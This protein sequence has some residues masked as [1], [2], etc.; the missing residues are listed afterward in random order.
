[1]SAGGLSYSALVNSGKSTLPSVDGWGT[2]M[3]ILRD[4]PKSITTRKIDKVGSDHDITQQI[5]DSGD[6]ACESIRRF[7]RGVNPSV[8]VSYGNTGSSQSG[9]I[10]SGGQQN[11][12]LPYKIMDG[13][14]F[15][16]PVLRQEQ[17]LPLSR[18]PRATTSAYSQPGRPDYSKKMV[19][20]GKS[21]DMRSV[22]TDTLKTFVRPTK[23]YTI[24]S[25]YSKDKAREPF[26]VKY[27]IQPKL[28]TQAHSGLRTR[29][30]TQQ[31]V[32][33]PTREVMKNALRARANINKNDDRVYKRSFNDDINIDR[34]TQSTLSHSVASNPNANIARKALQEAADRGRRGT[35]EQ[36]RNTSRSAPIS[37][38]EKVKYIHS[39]IETSRN[40][41]QH[42]ARTNI[43]N[44]RKHVNIEADNEIEMDRKL[45]QHKAHTNKGDKTTY[46]YHEPEN[47][48]TYTRNIPSG[49]YASNVKGKG[50]GVSTESSRDYSL[51]PKIH[52]GSFSTPASKPMLERNQDVHVLPES[53]RARMSRIV[54][55]EMQ[56]R[57]SHPVPSTR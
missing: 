12:S 34:Y 24:E 43:H 14:A 32:K 28:S 40:L 41:P 19:Q 11:A 31:D 21:R 55:E 57:Y 23:R 29:D 16:P 22:K 25:P 9:N 53:E 17:L 15:R 37:G 38:H 3:N 49:E 13:G 45:P 20:P 46:I 30:I 47:T 27:V 8:S 33:V 35:H 44:S 2:N 7:A 52:A 48:L 51:A 1:M 4:P 5:E 6:R 56:G 26:E 39:D 54:N 10:S 50:E 42:M 18:Q 36:V